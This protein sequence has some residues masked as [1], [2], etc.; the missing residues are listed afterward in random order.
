MI[1]D[2]YDLTVLLQSPIYTQDS[3]GQ[4]IS[5]WSSGVNLN[6]TI[7]GRS[8]SYPVTSGIQYETKSYRLYCSVNSSI[9]LQDRIYYN[10][11]YYYVTYINE[12]LRNDSHLQVDL[13]LGRGDRN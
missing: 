3:Y 12:L 13:E 6:C 10:N 5:S 1:S 8:G 2:Y 9:A 11:Q 7:Q 4:N